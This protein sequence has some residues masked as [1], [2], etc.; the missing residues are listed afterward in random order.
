MT[1]CSEKGVIDIFWEFGQKIVKHP[2][3]RFRQNCQ[4]CLFRLQRNNVGFCFFWKKY[5]LLVFLGFESKSLQFH[6]KFFQQV[7]ENC[8]FCVQRNI[9]DEKFFYRI[10][11]IILLIG[12][13]VKTFRRLSKKISAGLW[14]LHSRGPGESFQK[15]IFF[16]VHSFKNIFGLFKNFFSFFSYL[17]QCCY[18]CTLRVKMKVSGTKRLLAVLWI[19]LFIWILNGKCRSWDKR[20][21]SKL[22]S[23]L[24]ED[25]Y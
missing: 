18:L 5:Q 13:W 11:K 2:A 4:N 16:K 15:E 12:L 3:N 20:G 6:Q 10:Y 19:R 8:I 1:L 23:T 14:K 25:H 9:F 24:P 7:C 21:S 22:Y 17:Q